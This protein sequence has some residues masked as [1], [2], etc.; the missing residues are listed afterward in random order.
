MATCNAQY[1]GFYTN[2]AS[3][4]NGTSWSLFAFGPNACT[5]IA[6]FAAIIEAPQP[7]ACPADLNGDGSVDGQ[8]LGI[9]LG[10]W[11][12]DGPADLNGDSTVDGIDLGIL[13]GNW[14]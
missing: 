12:A 10:G 8:D 1:V 9:L 4:F 11:G 6:Q 5:Q 14:G 7:V 3:F 2:N 13:L